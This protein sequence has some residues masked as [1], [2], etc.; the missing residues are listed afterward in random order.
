VSSRSLVAPALF[1]LAL[2]VGLS[3]LLPTV[4]G[5]ALA[6]P[7]YYRAGNPEYGMSVFVYGN[8]GTTARDFGKLQ[9][10][11][12]WWQKSLFR[13]RDIETDCKGCFKWD[14]ADRVV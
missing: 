11:N 1:A 4:A 6:A 2:L 7:S 5:S 14:E 9:E 12:F 10:L 13:W 8:P 3:T